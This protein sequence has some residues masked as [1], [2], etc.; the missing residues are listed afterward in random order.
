MRLRLALVTLASTTMVVVAL[1]V[2]LFIL[3]GNQARDRA[4]ATAER[5]AQTT[6]IALTLAAADGV[7]AGEATSVLDAFGVEDVSVILADGTVVGHEARSDDLTLEARRG[8]A[9]TVDLDDGAVSV[10]VPVLGAADEVTVVRVDVEPEALT[11]GVMR[12]R[13][14]LGL[15]GAFLITVSV[16]VADRLARRTVSPV[17]ALGDAAQRL[18]GGDLDT[19]V[20]PSGPPEVEAVG[21]AFNDLAARV[22]DLLAAERESAA[23]ISHRL[24]TPLTALR[25]QIDGIVDNEVRDDLALQADRLQNA[26]TE[27]ITEARTPRHDAAAKSD[28][29]AVVGHRVAFWKVLATEQRRTIS[30]PSLET[31]AHIDVS[32][33]DAAAVIDTLLENFFAHTPAGTDC[34]IAVRRSAGRVTLG[35]RDNGPGFSSPGAIA[36][37]A[38]GSKSSGLGLDIV[39][40]IAERAGGGVDIED[41]PGAGLTVSF[42]SWS[43]PQG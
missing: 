42:A 8:L 9:A 11:A 24:R 18:G 28:L 36:R 21:H 2:P 4:L 7:T 35:Y 32:E 41:G 10:L 12:A 26:I 19:R 14:I 34:E 16:L 25:L 20:V 40:K 43:A 37:G 31:P 15:L 5:N 13:V 38:S 29:A 3:V 6:A 30:V 22:S 17:E 27:V 1:L 23:D 39:R 33:Q